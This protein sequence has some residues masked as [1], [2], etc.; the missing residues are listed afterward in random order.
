MALITVTSWKA[1]SGKGQIM[2][3]GQLESETKSKFQYRI[4]A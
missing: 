2:Q 1:S 4:A 3:A